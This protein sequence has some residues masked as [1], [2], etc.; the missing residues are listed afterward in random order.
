MYLAMG[1]NVNRLRTAT[2]PLPFD[3]FAGK[4]TFFIFLLMILLFSF[5]IAL[6]YRYSSRKVL[7]VENREF[8]NRLSRSLLIIRDSIN[9]T[10]LA[11]SATLDKVYNNFEDVSHFPKATES[12]LS[13][14]GNT[15]GSAI[16]LESTA[17]G[18]NY[19]VYSSKTDLGD[20]KTIV[21]PE[22]DYKSWD[23]YSD[24]ERSL[25][26][27]WGDPYYD[28]SLSDR[29]LCTYSYP[30]FKADGSFAGVF[31]ADITLEDYEKLLESLRP[32]DDDLCQTEL[33]GKN[34]SYIA[35]PT[36]PKDTIVDIRTCDKYTPE[37]LDYIFSNEN[38]SQVSS[39]DGEEC[40]VV[41]T[42]V[43]ESIGWRL[44]MVCPMDVIMADMK[45]VLIL[46]GLSNLLFLL[47]LLTLVYVVVH[48]VL[49]PITTLSDSVQRI[50]EDLDTPVPDMKGVTEIN[51]LRDSME[52]M[53][54]SLC[55]YI[56]EVR[57]MTKENER[58][59]NELNIAREIQNAMLPPA[60]PAFD[61]HEEFS[62][63]AYIRPAREVGG[64]LYDYILRDG[65]LF[66]LIGDSSGKGVPASMF[67]AST[68]YLYRAFA[69]YNDSASDIVS[70]LNNALCRNNATNMF[71]TMIAGVL[72][73][74]EG[75]LELCN[76]GHTPPLSVC[77][78]LNDYVKLESNIPVGALE[79]FSY[80]S[81]FF[82]I[83]EGDSLI[84][85]TDGVTEAENAAGELFGKK[86]LL[87]TVRSVPGDMIEGIVGAI[88]EFTDG[89]EQ[90][91]DITIM[92]ISLDKCLVQKN[93]TLSNKI[94]ELDRIRECIESASEE[95]G[96]GKSGQKM[97]L[98]VEEAATNIISY[99][100]PE[101]ENGSF[102]FSL[103]VFHNSAVAVLKDRGKAFNP[104]EA[105]LPDIDGPLQDRPVGGL[106]VMLMRKL[107]D[108]AT[109]RRSCDGT[110]ILTLK[111]NIEHGNNN[112]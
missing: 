48:N 71:E 6:D 104:L 106:G 89:V 61:A 109:Y 103:K 108:R 79:D 74:E 29:Y 3:S 38:G 57:Q 4:L 37:A 93:L 30:L 19:M 87:E 64:D 32:Y 82:K 67:M 51:R 94:E 59:E 16:A 85:Y 47:L 45:R 75:T 40:L 11:L 55:N 73:L 21:I 36:I 13:L 12:L 26:P 66:F 25:K 52:S 76:A 101:G 96:F 20:I 107:S 34:G 43:D 33:I 9:N 31:T 99:S 24:I 84:F 49:K 91:D 110:N 77:S 56:D 111:F 54:K 62:L 69:M 18:G 15:Y 81:N 28:K 53:R 27:V 100:F 88:G 22:Y 105:P 2:K 97:M 41:H 5:K 44:I 95:C 63:S 86:R 50:A 68:S 14:S 58:I 39:V 98:A 83:S 65:K 70:K 102:S 80:K 112:K 46:T 78:A 72:D 1:H 23:W 35:S 8:V 60:H 90:S 17:N 7:E 42:L 10:E 92:A